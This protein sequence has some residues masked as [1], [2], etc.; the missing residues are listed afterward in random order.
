MEKETI[1]KVLKISIKFKWCD[2]TLIIEPYRD[3]WTGGQIVLIFSRPQQNVYELSE[4]MKSLK[5]DEKLSQKI[6]LCF[7]SFS[8]FESFCESL[9]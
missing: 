8:I 4:C 5:G 6:L 7:I 1:K 9:F 2:F 3:S